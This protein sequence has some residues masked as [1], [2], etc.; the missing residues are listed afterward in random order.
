MMTDLALAGLLVLAWE[1]L[2][3]SVDKDKPPKPMPPTPSMTRR[4]MPGE[5]AGVESTMR[6]MTSSQG[7]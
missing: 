4:D 7:E 6:N 1:R 5:R 3:S 2:A